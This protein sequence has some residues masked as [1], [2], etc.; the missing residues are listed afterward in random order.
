LD[1][2][3]WLA[4]SRP[5]G[6]A[7]F[8]LAASELAGYDIVPPVDRELD[9]E[10]LSVI[11]AEHGAEQVLSTVSSFSGPRHHAVSTSSEP[12]EVHRRVR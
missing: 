12:S 1:G 6:F 9:M 4:V 5:A 2:A 7:S 11:A 8:V 10:A 3:R